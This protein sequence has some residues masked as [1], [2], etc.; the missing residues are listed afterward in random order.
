LIEIKTYLTGTEKAP[1]GPKKVNVEHIFSQSPTDTWVTTF[2]AKGAED[3]YTSRLGNM[4]LLDAKLNKQCS[5]KPY[6]E[7]QKTYYMKSDFTITNQL[8]V[9]SHWTVNS[10]DSRQAELL[11]FAIKIWGIE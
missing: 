8:G 1:A 4:T 3:S 2:G 6:A 9:M 7:K 10:V 11:K 5:S